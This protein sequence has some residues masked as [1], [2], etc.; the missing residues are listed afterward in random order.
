MYKIKRLFVAL[1]IAGQFTLSSCIFINEVDQPATADLNE[2]ITIDVV[3]EN[4]E[5]EW[6]GS[7]SVGLAAIMMPTDWTVEGV[8]YDGD[9]YGPGT[10]DYLH[11]DSA[12][13]QP[14]VGTDLW[15]DTLVVFYPPGD[16][17]DWYVF[18]S[19][20][21]TWLG[22]TTVTTVTFE[23]TT[24]AAGTYNL[25]YYMN[26]ADFHFSDA[27]FPGPIS[28]GNTIVVADPTGLDDTPE[29]AKGFALKQNFPNPFNP[30]T[31]IQY[32][33][34]KRSSVNLTVYNLIGK[35]VAVLVNGFQNAGEHEVNFDG[36][37][38]PSGVYIYKLRAGASTE[39]RKM[40]LIK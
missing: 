36:A 37:N 12:D 15:R 11:P 31:K 22:D 14:G 27:D 1:F 5:D 29:I 9:F 28:Q 18:Q 39:T 23:L 21:F 8:T 38:L 6:A 33:I 13:R 7:S 2:T 4:H 20:L 17:M 30:I 24:G 19:E 10:L 3:V 40:A 25:A 34:E 26:S 16:G 32:E 35:E